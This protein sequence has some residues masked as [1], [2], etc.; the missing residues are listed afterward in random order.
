MITLFA[1]AQRMSTISVCEPVLV[2]MDGCVEPFAPAS[3][4]AISSAVDR[5]TGALM[6]SGT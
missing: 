1:M 6:R 3:E 5:K 2:L 4:L